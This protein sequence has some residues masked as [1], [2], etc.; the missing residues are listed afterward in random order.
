MSLQAT[1]KRVAEKKTQLDARRPLPEATAARLKDQFD[2]EWTYHTNALSSSTLTLRETEIIL[3]QGLTIGGKTL[4]EHLEALNHKKA[5][6]L[7]ETLAREAEPPNENHL[8]QVHALL[9]NRIDDQEAGR[10]RRGPARIRGAEYLPPEAAAVPGLMSDFFPW[11][12]RIA[13]RLS[14]VERAASA[15]YRLLD[16]HPFTDSNGR[17]ARLLMNLILLRA[18]Y[19]PAIVRS[20]ERPAY[21]TT[22][23]QACAGQTKPFMQLIAEAVERSLDI[24]LAA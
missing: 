24:Y 22:L 19:P 15:H 6:D 2:A 5:I 3:H 21:H 14:M 17:M 1:L 9:L 12:D 23:D 11:L 20:E 16:I 18:G 8:R 4:E 10:Y 7:V 13:Q